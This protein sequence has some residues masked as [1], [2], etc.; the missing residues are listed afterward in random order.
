MAD[1]SRQWLLTGSQEPEVAAKGVKEELASVGSSL[2]TTLAFISFRRI[3]LQKY[4]KKDFPKN[5]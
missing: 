4:T 2:P 5:A 1:N 3:V